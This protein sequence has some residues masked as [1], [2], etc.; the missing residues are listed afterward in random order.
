MDQ[1]LARRE[2]LRIFRLVLIVQL[3]FLGF[4]FLALWKLG[5]EA[6][7]GFL[8]RASPTLLLSLLFLPRWL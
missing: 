6:W 2:A 4:S 1:T 5:A 8:L 3:V 7:W